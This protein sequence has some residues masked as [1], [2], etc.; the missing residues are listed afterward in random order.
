[1]Y[2]LSLRQEPRQC[3]SLSCWQPRT[4]GAPT[5]ISLVENDLRF[6]R[7]NLR[8]EIKASKSPRL[9]LTVTEIRDLGDI[10]RYL[11]RVETPGMGG[12][13]GG[14]V[15]GEGRLRIGKGG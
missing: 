9:G 10:S 8:G 13:C 6:S 3:D 11:K 1:M 4:V 12:S 7:I 14:G 5:F 15:G 2:T